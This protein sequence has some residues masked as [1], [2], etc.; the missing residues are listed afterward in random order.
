MAA[1]EKVVSY[2]ERQKD[3]LI[4]LLPGWLPAAILDLL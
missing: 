4:I 2:K 1:A 3:C